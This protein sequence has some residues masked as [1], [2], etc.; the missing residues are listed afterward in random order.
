MTFLKPTEVLEQRPEIKE[1]F[2]AKQLGALNW[3]GLVRGRPMRRGRVICLE[4]VEQIIKFK[5]ETFS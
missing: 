5:K 4:D 1:H 3:L 2:D